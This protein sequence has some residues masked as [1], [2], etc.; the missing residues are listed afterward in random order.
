MPMGLFNGSL[1]GSGGRIPVVRL[2]TRDLAKRGRCPQGWSPP[3]IESD[4]CGGIL[5][6]RTKAS[7]PA[8]LSSKMAWRR[9]LRVILF[10]LP[11]ASIAVRRNSIFVVWIG[12]IP[13]SCAWDV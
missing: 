10:C 1:P 6:R 11:M 4:A 5:G 7:R 12:V 8:C 2:E 13:S 3:V 9:K